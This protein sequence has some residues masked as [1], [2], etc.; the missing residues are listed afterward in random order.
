MDFT[1]ESG[2]VF[3]DGILKIVDYLIP[4]LLFHKNLEV[5]FHKSF[6]SIPSHT[7]SN[8]P[9]S[10]VSGKVVGSGYI[11]LITKYIHFVSSPSPAL[12][13]SGPTLVLKMTSAL[14]Y[15]R[16]IVLHSDIIFE[17]AVLK[18]CALSPFPISTTRDIYV[19]N[20]LLDPHEILYEI[21]IV[22]GSVTHSASARCW[23]DVT[24]FTTPITIQ[25]R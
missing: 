15:S 23:R 13:W 18:S 12:T 10:F 21:E 2:T 1:L 5:L 8:K 9:A 4:M 6:G 22:V 14:Q 24:C 20:V 17:N 3:V 11:A 16:A 25:S 19:R 7:C